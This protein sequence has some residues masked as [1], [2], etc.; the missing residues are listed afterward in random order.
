MDKCIFCGQASWRL[1]FKIEGNEFE[2][3]R[4]GDCGLVATWPQPTREELK[5]YYASDYYSFRELSAP[6][7]SKILSLEHFVRR[8]FFKQHYGREEKLNFKERLLLFFF[9]DR[10]G[11]FKKKIDFGK[12]LDIGAGDGFFLKSAKDLGWTV[13]GVEPS[14]S[15]AGFAT[16][17]G[18]NVFAGTLEE[19]KYE[20][21][22]FDIVRLSHSLEHTFDPA[23]T[24]REAYRIL[25]PGGSAIISVPN[26]SG[27]ALKLF[28]NKLDIPKHLFHFTPQTLKQYLL[29]CGFKEIEVNYYSVG[30]IQSGLPKFWQKKIFTPVFL[31]IDR[32][33]NIIKLGDSFVIIGSK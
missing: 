27:L 6:E 15:A 14:V 26:F 8:I 30:I 11:P 19:A 5:K 20:A 12:I 1:L 22:Y 29:Y 23:S 28:R 9:Q 7:Q 3:Q 18:L 33:L 4:C 10:F 25:R 16:S 32:L 31:L 2:L 13:A 24:L 21:D 17:Q